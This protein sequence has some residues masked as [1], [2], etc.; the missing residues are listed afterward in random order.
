MRWAVIGSTGLFGQDLLAFLKDNGQDVEG[1]NRTNLQLSAEPQEIAP[2]LAGFD[3]WVNCVGFTRVDEA[4]AEVYEAN[5]VNGIYAG[6]LA[7]SAEMAGSRFIQIS[8]DYVFDGLSGVP[9][10]VTDS[11]NPQTSYGR[12][13]ALGEQLVSE[14]G[15]DYSILRTAWLYGSNG[16]CF[17]KVVAK[18]LKRNG[19]V[20][21]VCDQRGQPTWTRDLAEIVFHVAQL[22]EMPRVFN[23]VAS[24]QATWAEFAKEVAISIGLSVNSVEEISSDEFPTAARRP[25]WSVLD[26]SNDVLKSIGDW[27]ARWYEA[28]PE[29]L[30]NLT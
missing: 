1:F 6:A 11:I 5:L 19:T 13:K 26:N 20:R 4:E 17:P 18:S 14:S 2:Q 9:Y 7:E 28:A 30:R 12:S 25:V 8:T 10:T 16:H 21:V 29:V 3:V 27:R 23:A 15:A 24:G 22:E